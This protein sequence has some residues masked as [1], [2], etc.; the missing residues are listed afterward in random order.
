MLISIIDLDYSTFHFI[1]EIMVNPFFDVLMPIIRSKS[2]WIPL[3][4]FIISFTFLNFKYRNA[5]FYILF[6]I[7]TIIISDF[8]SSQVI[9]KNVQRPRPCH[10]NSTYEGARVL[11]HC[12]GGYS[13][14]SSHATNHFALAIFLILTMGR[15]FRKTR[16]YLFLWAL[17]ISFAQVYVGV[18]FPLDILFGGILGICVGSLMA[19]IYNRFVKRNIYAPRHVNHGA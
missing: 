1:N 7:S 15:I 4:V 5:A 14:T 17:F 12:G 16:K 2:F 18:H 9:K 19:E 8:M 3:Y 6:L 11:V 10:Q 13:F